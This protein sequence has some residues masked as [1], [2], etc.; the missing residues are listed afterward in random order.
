MFAKQG[1]YKK[2]IDIYE[3]LSLQMPEKSDFFA[4]KIQKLRIKII[5]I[6]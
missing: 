5:S 1:N 4:A 2:A 6:F 3:R